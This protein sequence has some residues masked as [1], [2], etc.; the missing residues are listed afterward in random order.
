M[1]P[2]ED[3]GSVADSAF[4]AAAGLPRFAGLPLRKTKIARFCGQFS[5]IAALFIFFRF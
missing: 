1:S 4:L 5:I 2:V 3:R